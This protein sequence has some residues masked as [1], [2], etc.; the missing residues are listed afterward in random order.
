MRKRKDTSF[1]LVG[2]L[3][4][5][6]SVKVSMIS[7]QLDISRLNEPQDTRNYVKRYLRSEI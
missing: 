1:S 5:G 7:Q 4:L 6:Q 2:G 3:I